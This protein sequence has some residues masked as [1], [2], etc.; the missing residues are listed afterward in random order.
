MFD[1]DGNVEIVEQVEAL[2]Y[3]LEPGGALRSRGAVEGGPHEARWRRGVARKAEEPRIAARRPQRYAV[4]PADGG[5]ARIEVHVI[6]QVGELPLETG[7]V[8][9]H[10][11]LIFVKMRHSAD[12]FQHDLPSGRFSDAPV[13]DRR[14]FQRNDAHASDGGFD[15][16]DGRK[17]CQHPCHEL[18]IGERAVV[19]RRFVGFIP[20]VLRKE[21]ESGR[22]PR[23]VDPLGDELLLHHGQPHDAVFG[24]EGHAV[25]SQGCKGAEPLTARDDDVFALQNAA[26]PLDGARLHITAISSR[27]RDARAGDRLKGTAADSGH[28]Q[29]QIPCFHNRPVYGEYLC[30]RPKFRANSRRRRY[31][32]A[33]RPMV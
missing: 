13:Y 10:T 12:D 19:L 24:R 23:F 29:Q 32:A 14:L 5:V 28:T 6:V 27:E 30:T 11:D 9:E 8:G 33:G 7:G 2:L 18:Q 21:E 22:Q 26:G 20:S 17:L 4:Q 25:G 31:P 3:G 1:A 16:I 15:L